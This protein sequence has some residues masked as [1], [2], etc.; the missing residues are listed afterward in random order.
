[1]MAGYLARSTW[2]HQVPAGAKLLALAGISIA[3]IPVSTWPPLA[4]AL[5]IVIASYA[6]LGREALRRMVTF[7]RALLPILMVIGVL[8]GLTQSWEAGAT[9]VIRLLL[10]VLLADIVTM[11][12]TMQAMMAALLP[13]LRP[14][15]AIGLN[16]KSLT[17]AVALVVRFVPV[18]MAAWQE[19][20]E[21][22][23]ARTGR[24]S[25]VKLLA[26]FVAETLRLADSVA[27]ALDA[28]GFG[29]PRE[30]AGSA[31]DSTLEAKR[32]HGT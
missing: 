12:T 23:R 7:G 26:P 20:D 4:V 17:L 25:S 8:Q 1:M 31:L 27:E 16:P 11:T 10:M 9:S 15:R 18:L 19:R 30:N 14:L 22:W 24:R 5:G 3:L 2:L 13:V 29:G 28:R 32:R 6:A 21:A